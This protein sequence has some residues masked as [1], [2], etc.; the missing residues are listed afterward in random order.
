[1][2]TASKGVKARPPSAQRVRKVLV[3]HGPNLNLLGTREPHIYGRDTLA[4]IHDGLA[5]RLGAEGTEDPGPMASAAE[6]ALEL[7]FLTRKLAKAPSD[8]GDTVSYG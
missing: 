5:Q 8:D 2:K 4:Q 7:L 1:M 3:L 6:L